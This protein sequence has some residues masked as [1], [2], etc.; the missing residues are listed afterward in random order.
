MGNTLT[1]NLIDEFL[2]VKESEGMS[3]ACVDKYKLALS[4]FTKWLNNEE[5][6]K[7]KYF[8]FLKLLHESN[9]SDSYQKT[10]AQ[11]IKTCIR[12][13]ISAGYEFPLPDFKMPR[14]HKKKLC[15]LEE[16]QIKKLIKSNLS[17]KELSAVRLLVTTG[18][19]LNE[20]CMLDWSD[21]NF[22]TGAIEVRFAK[23][24]KFRFVV[25][26]KKTLV[27][28][29]KLKNKNGISDLHCPVFSHGNNRRFTKMG[30]RSLLLRIRE[31]TSI[32]FTA[33][34]LRRSF[35]R[36]AILKGM[37]SIW[38]QQLMGHSSIEMTRHYIGQL[39]INDVVKAYNNNLPLSF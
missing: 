13:L 10:N 17:I 35:A 4:K 34:A 29:M 5:L 23:M 2:L 32:Y 14:I 24:D 15:Y 16:D 20:M 30:M 8:E 1:Q 7:I 27:I 3:S 31:K 9:L 6:T 36:Q 26:D 21:I 39:D 18:L 19:R 12:Y 38:I 28:L 37:D 22:K 33:H 25:T 11:V